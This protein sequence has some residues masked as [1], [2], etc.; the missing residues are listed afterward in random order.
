MSLEIYVDAYS[1]YKANERP[2]QFVLDEDVFQIE[3]VEHLWRTRDAMFFKVRTTNG[4]HCVLR[5]VEGPN[6]W[7][8]QNDLD[9]AELLARTSIE[10]ISV[11][12]A[13]IREAE[14]R[15]AA[16]GQCRPMESEILFDS[17]LADVLNKH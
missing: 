11:E 7:T 5:Y 13:T 16:C 6:E 4:K 14:S 9:G 15:I 10:L 12:P 1:G 8:L 3:S 17:I 2:R